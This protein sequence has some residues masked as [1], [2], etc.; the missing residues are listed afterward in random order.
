MATYFIIETVTREGMTTVAD[1]PAR[2]SGV[3][4][5]AK[6]YGIE[7]SE[8]FYTTGAS[9]FIMKVEAPD[10]D[11]VAVFTMALRSSGNVTV[12]VLKAYLPSTWAELV[13]R[14]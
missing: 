8:W 6:K 12:K 3:P 10:D 2:S 4:D 5:L 7:L 11:A 14:L 13:E 9:D 1:A